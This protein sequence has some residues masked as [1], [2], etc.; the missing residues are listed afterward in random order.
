VPELE[1]VLLGDSDEAALPDDDCEAECEVN[2]MDDFGEIVSRAEADALADALTL[3]TDADAEDV[4]DATSVN[5]A[6]AVTDEEAVAKALAETIALAVPDTVVVSVACDIDADADAQDDC[7]GVEER[8]APLT[9]ASGEIDTENDGAPESLACAVTD[10]ENDA[11]ADADDDL[12]VEA[13][14][15]AEKD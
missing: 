15:E 1:S 8:V 4:P 11:R 9:L 14:L 12:V 6:C 7:D 13:D 10:I 5:E 3:R 2:D